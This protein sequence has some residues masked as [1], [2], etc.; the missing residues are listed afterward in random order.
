MN[1]KYMNFFAITIIMALFL[2]VDAY[3]QAD[4]MDEEMMD[5]VYEEPEAIGETYE[6]MIVG[7]VLIIGKDM[8]RV[9][10]DSTGNIYD[11]NVNDEM[12]EDVSTGYRIAVKTT[13]GEVEYIRMLGL[14]KEAEPTIVPAE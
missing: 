3:S 14:H 5:D 9:R 11:L 8:I 6:D 4:H 12:I 2:S 1:I 13:D 10:E 7:K